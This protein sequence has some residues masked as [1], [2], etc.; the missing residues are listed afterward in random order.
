MTIFFEDDGEAHSDGDDL[1]LGGWVK[2]YATYAEHTY[3][4]EL[5]YTGS[6]SLRFRN[7]GTGN[8]Y[9]YWYHALTGPALP[10]ILTVWFYDNGLT[11]S[12]ITALLSLWESSVD[13]YAQIGVK[14]YAS[15][16]HYCTCAPGEWS[17]TISS[18]A[19]S[20]G[21]HKF[22]IE[23]RD[24]RII[25]RI[26]DIEVRN[27]TTNIFVASPSRLLIYCR[28]NIT[29]FYYDNIKVQSAAPPDEYSINR[30]FLAFD[31]SMIP[32]GKRSIIDSAYIRVYI[33]SIDNNVDPDDDLCLVQGT[34]DSVASLALS[35]YSKV[36]DTIGGS[37]A[38]GSVVINAWNDIILNATGLGMIN[39]GGY[40]KLGLRSK[41]DIDAT[42]EDKFF[43][44][45]CSEKAGY[46]PILH[47]KY[48][49]YI[50]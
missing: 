41:K 31:T 50:L 3:S 5:P 40:T 16:T 23:V 4:N 6:I 8:V 19:R 26:D 12:Y 1:T 43:H 20:V 34:Q 2:K 15:Q 49:P 10:M 33:T 42:P 38:G 17:F 45:Y 30:G 24:V 47:V 7:T 11:T 25:Y 22:E 35:D 37:I 32:S 36:G 46:C 39:K 14:G 48:I 13:T 28:K 27:E 9:N 18:V 29:P 21:W 44:F